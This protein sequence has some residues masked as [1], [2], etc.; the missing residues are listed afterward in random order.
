MY[1]IRPKD[2]YITY[3]GISGILF[4]RQF[5]LGM[6]PRFWIGARYHKVT[7]N[8]MKEKII[9]FMIGYLSWN[10][11]ESKVYYTM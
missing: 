1:L 3:I 10:T 2:N 9:R 11:L 7:V 5:T 6:V 8:G 4:G